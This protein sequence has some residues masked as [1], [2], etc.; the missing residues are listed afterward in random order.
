MKIDR[1]TLIVVV[2]VFGLGYWYA[3]KNAAPPS[4]HKDRPLLRWVVKLAKA[5]LWVALFAEGPPEDEPRHALVHARAGA[6]GEP[7]LEHGEGW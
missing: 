3:S 1:Q 6:D 2:V 7:L 4:P 5:G